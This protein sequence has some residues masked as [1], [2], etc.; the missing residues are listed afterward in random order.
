MTLKAV[1]AKFGDALILTTD[2]ATV[3]IDGGPAG[4]YKKFLS[5]HI[6]LMDDGG[7]IRLR[8]T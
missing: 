5:K 7:W 4:V 1:K 2:D 3:L 6:A 8:S